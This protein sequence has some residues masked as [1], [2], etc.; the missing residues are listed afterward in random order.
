[1][2]E[3]LEELKHDPLPFLL[4]STSRPLVYF[5]KRDLLD[6]NLGRVQGLWGDLGVQ[7]IISKQRPD[8]SWPYPGGNRRIRSQEDYDQIETYRQLGVLVEEYGLDRSHSAVKR[9]A[10]FFFAH[11]TKEGDIRGI[12]GRQY[13]PNYTAGIIELL[14]KAGLGNERRILRGFD[15]LISVRQ[16]DG[17]WAIPFR[18]SGMSSQRSWTDVLRSK[19]IQPD[20]S[21]PFSHLVTGVVL[22]AFAAHERYRK[23]EEAWIAGRLM[24]RRFFKPDAYADRKAPEFW[25]SVSFP[26]WFTDTVSALDS[27]SL[28]GFD[29]KNQ[30]IQES[31]NWLKTR[32]RSDG[33]FGLKLLRTRDKSLNH[34]VS[35]AIC[36]V[37]KR[38]YGSG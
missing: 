38:F 30:G 11:Q 21:K 37:F 26:F 12:Y 25:E 28:I 36:R 33:S 8:G 4:G 23:S 31:L 5:V 34:W 7:K 29:S 27:L 9:A 14:V 20:F 6:Q 17:G 35:L 16:K 10:R 1:M 15:W 22:R 2:A 19:P 3:W 32:Q 13:S 24:S 18:T